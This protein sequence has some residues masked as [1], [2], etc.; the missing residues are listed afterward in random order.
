MRQPGQK[1][2]ASNGE[3]SSIQIA[4]EGFLRA[5][6]KR[7]GRKAK[8]A[9]SIS[10]SLAREELALEGYLNRVREPLE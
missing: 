8:V 7:W 6:V 5:C 10:N 1:L 2:I 4:K 3:T 9:F